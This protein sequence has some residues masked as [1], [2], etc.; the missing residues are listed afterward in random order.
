MESRDQQRQGGLTRDPGPAR[1][2]LA[3]LFER[4][5]GKVEGGGEEPTL[6]CFMGYGEALESVRR[7]VH[8]ILNT[9][10]VL[11]VPGRL[12]TTLEYGLPDFAHVSATDMQ[13]RAVLA[14]Q[15]A[16]TIEAFEP[17]LSQVRVNLE[18][19]PSGQRFLVGTV[20]AN[21]TI[22]IIPEPVSFPL[23]VDSA[24]MPAEAIL[25]APK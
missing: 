14:L 13:G 12:L 1:R 10:T 15:I 11:Q 9:R 5:T 19:H 8:R 20:T 25:V 7:E 17:R 2:L 18:P 6:Y 21:L 24:L 4:L 3:P 22:T 23:Q 16:R